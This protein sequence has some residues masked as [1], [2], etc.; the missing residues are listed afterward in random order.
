MYVKTRK[1]GNYEKIIEVKN[2]FVQSRFFLNSPYR[3]SKRMKE[4]FHILKLNKLN[5]NEKI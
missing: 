4:I 1:K 5:S 3:K 2:Q